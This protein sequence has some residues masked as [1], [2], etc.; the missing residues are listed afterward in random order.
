MGRKILASNE[1]GAALKIKPLT[2]T[3]GSVDQSKTFETGALDAILEVLADLLAYFFSGT[4]IDAPS[5]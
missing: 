4:S 2:D 3:R 5:C 1:D